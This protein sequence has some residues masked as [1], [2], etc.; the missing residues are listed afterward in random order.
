M[1]DNGE[2][3]ASFDEMNASALQQSQSLGALNSQEQ[4]SRGV[5]AE[6]YQQALQD[7]A[8]LAR[9]VRSLQD[10]LAITSA[11]KEAFRAQAQRLEKEF[12]KGR[13]QADNLQRE[14][15]ESKREAQVLTQQNQEAMQMVG[16]MRKAHI[17]EVRLLQRGLAMR[18]SD[19]D[20]RNRVN[21][22]ADLVDKLGRAV[23]QRDESI[24][25]KTKMQVQ[26]SKV[27]A[28]ARALTLDCGKL[29]QQNKKLSESL[30]EAQR[31]AKFVPP[32]PQQEPV[33]DSDEEFEG[34]L[35][36]FE[37]RFQIMEEGPA[38]LDILASNL[39][40]DKRD[41]ELRL[42]KQLEVA[43]DL[44]A[45]IDNWKRIC[46]DKDLQ[47]RE[48]SA[49]LEKVLRDQALLNEQIAQKRREI[50]LQ[51]AEEKK[52]LEKRV[53]ELEQECDN[54]RQAA[55]G[56]EK[57]SNR[58]S[59]ELAKV[60]EQ[61]QKQSEARPGEKVP[62]SSTAGTAPAPPQAATATP[63][64]APKETPAAASDE[65][66]ADAPKEVLKAS[67]QQA[68]TGETLQLEVVRAGNVHELRAS[69]GDGEQGSS[70]V[71]EDL[72][73]ELDQA[74]PWT[75]LFARV[76]V[77]LGPPRRIVISSVIGHREVELPPGGTSVRI[78]VW[79][80]DARRFYLSALLLSSGTLVDV[81]VMEDSL[82]PQHEQQMDNCGSD[83]ELLDFFAKAL[84]YDEGTGRL[85][86]GAAQ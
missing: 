23:V 14:V 72:L 47:I 34:E 1:I 16:E 29:R 79:R 12:K 84:S 86:F 33:E 4:L 64:D 36:A 54:A 32:M 21:E 2:K 11:K 28:D 52:A 39:S 9:K 81:M 82:T 57:A 71:N 53:N 77:S 68:K 58:L 80:Y 62:D 5:Q 50:E 83:D 13:E 41:L 18:G 17:H 7:S 38:G 24:R 70:Q 37:K 75:D 6:K 45:T 61:Y 19:K 49:K 15:L 10:Q 56:M 20:L 43:A 8:K 67:T 48:Q 55:D 44:N 74:D 59:S 3:D 65:T 69:E 35:M 78:T 22:T 27:E 51:V 63:A 42:K 85:T 30:K 73:A 40:R 60:H 26:L 25:D 46:G 76:G 66:P 31:K